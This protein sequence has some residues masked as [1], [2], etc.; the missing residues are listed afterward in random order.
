M[1]LCPKDRGVSFENIL[2]LPWAEALIDI[3]RE[4]DIIKKETSYFIF[5][6]KF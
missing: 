2:L 6:H 5:P 3:L 1:P 4:Y